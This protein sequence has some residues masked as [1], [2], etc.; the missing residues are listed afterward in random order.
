MC[1]LG[2]FAE[3]AVVP[4]RSVTKVPDELPLKLVALLGCGVLTGFGA[5][6]NTAAIQPGDSVAV[7]GCGGVGLNVIQGARVSGA[8]EIIAVDRVPLKLEMAKQFGA[9]R[10]ISAVDGDPVASVFDATSGQGVD[11]A[12]EVIG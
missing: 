10:M 3:H 6:V 11:H 12:F 1:C 4:E 9:T 2:T 5:A 8:G 7:I